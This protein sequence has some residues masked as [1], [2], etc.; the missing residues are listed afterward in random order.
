M[1]LANSCE[2]A[3]LNRTGQNFA[4]PMFIS[5]GVNYIQKKI[6]VAPA[7]SFQT[8][9]RDKLVKYQYLAYYK[10]QHLSYGYLPKITLELE[11]I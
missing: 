4:E 7:S 6:P 10:S 1:A 2:F 3:K 8:K 11:L 9:L 5:S